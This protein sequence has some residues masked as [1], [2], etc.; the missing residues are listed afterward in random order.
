M[1]EKTYPKNCFSS[2]V[3]HTKTRRPYLSPE[4]RLAIYIKRISGEARQTI[5]D[6]YFIIPQTV[7][8]IVKNFKTYGTTETLKKLVD[9][10]RLTDTQT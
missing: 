5:A 9:R 10:R 6:D 7:S 3:Q 1:G 2:P 8:H 4:E